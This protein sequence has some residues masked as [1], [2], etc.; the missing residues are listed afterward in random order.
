MGLE[1]CGPSKIMKADDEMTSRPVCD[2]AQTSDDPKKSQHGSSMPHKGATG[3]KRL[4]NK[5]QNL[6]V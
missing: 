5:E 4:N 2:L 3:L 1:S 6:E